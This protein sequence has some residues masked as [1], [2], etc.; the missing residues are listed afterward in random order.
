MKVNASRKAPLSAPK[1]SEP[2]AHRTTIVR[3]ACGQVQQRD[4]YSK[5]CGILSEVQELAL[6]AEINRLTDNGLPPTHV[7]V[8]NFAEDI[9]PKRPGKTGPESSS[10][11][12][13]KS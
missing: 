5:S 10:N 7:M 11:G 8:R 2:I 12:I 1:T 6:V 13:E 4:T 3:R 9:A